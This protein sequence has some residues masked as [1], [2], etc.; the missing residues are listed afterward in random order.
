MVCELHARGTAL[1]L[2]EHLV[3]RLSLPAV[4][5]AASLRQLRTGG[6]ASAATTA[7]AGA[8]SAASAASDAANRAATD[9]AVADGA[10]AEQAEVD[11]QSWSASQPIAHSDNN[12]AGRQQEVDNDAAIDGVADES[13][14]AQH[15]SAQ[16]AQQH[17]PASR[18][19]ARHSRLCE[20]RQ[21]R[22]E[23]Q[24]QQQ[25]Q[26]K[27]YHTRYATHIASEQHASNGAWQ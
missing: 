26:R 24:Q 17:V 23:Q 7:D 16:V 21:R 15:G 2:L 4:A 8:A 12:C 1:L 6:Y 25:Q 9:A 27:S 11:T 19:T 3:L 22:R 18:L 5:L 13:T 14:A 10:D 20:Q